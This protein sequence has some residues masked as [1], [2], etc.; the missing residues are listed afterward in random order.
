MV[1]TTGRIRDTEIGERE[2][3]GARYT[4]TQVKMAWTR[5]SRAALREHD[6][7]VDPMGVTRGRLLS[8]IR[9]GQVHNQLG[10]QLA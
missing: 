2:D 7:L 1:T 10:K 4:L 6:R 5:H 8:F 9:I 3:E